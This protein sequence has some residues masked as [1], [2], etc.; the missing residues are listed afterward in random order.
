MVNQVIDKIL[1]QD[2]SGGITVNIL[3]FGQA[4]QQLSVDDG[5]TELPQ[6][7]PKNTGLTIPTVIRQIQY[8]FELEQQKMEELLDMLPDPKID[9]IIALIFR[10]AA[11]KRETCLEVG[12]YLGMSGYRVRNWLA[13]LQI[14]PTKAEI[15]NDQSNL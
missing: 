8:E 13:K 12:R 6:S 15:E 2:K 1:R 7:I 9:H 5:K 10:V 4:I 11:K 14:K 3:Q